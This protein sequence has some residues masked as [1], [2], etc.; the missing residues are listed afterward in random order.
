MWTGRLNHV[1]NGFGQSLAAMVLGELLDGLSTG[2]HHALLARHQL[3]QERRVIDR[4]EDRP[5]SGRRTDTD[6]PVSQRLFWRRMISTVDGEGFVAAGVDIP[7]VPAV[8]PVGTVPQCRRAGP[9]VPVGYRRL[10]PRSPHRPQSI[11]CDARRGA[12]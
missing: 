4:G 3:V 5:V 7:Q 1:D 9:L 10:R 6:L 11:S 8:R 2:P 12:G